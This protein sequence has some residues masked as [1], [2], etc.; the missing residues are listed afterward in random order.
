MS[1]RVSASSLLERARAQRTAPSE[2]ERLH[3]RIAALAALVG[4]GTGLLGRAVVA[5]LPRPNDSA[6]RAVT[7]IIDHR[8][9]VLVG[10][11]LASVA[12]TASLAFMLGL[13]N[14]LRAGERSD[15]VLADLGL[16]AGAAVFVVDAV[17]AAFIG[18]SGFEAG[19]GLN[20]EATAALAHAG[21]VLGNLS[22]VPLLVVVAC[23]GLL[24][25]RSST[26]W[27][28]LGWAFGV[29]GL[30]SVG[31]ACSLARVGVLGLNGPFA[32]AAPLALTVWILVAG[33]A[34]VRGLL[35]S[36]P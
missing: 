22:A 31:A 13:R 36:R 32:I 26:P 19:R 2:Q 12:A 18:A 14:L 16:L 5:L 35:P 10:A 33:G 30:L 29:V 1:R 4:A 34:L 27:P 8:A 3:A 23:F 17:A 24:M 6:P 7:W 21:L 9:L 28:A 25:L 11:L 20:A 15:A